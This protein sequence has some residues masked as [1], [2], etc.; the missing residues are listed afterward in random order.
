[1]ESIPIRGQKMTR[2]LPPPYLAGKEFKV[3]NKGPLLRGKQ[4]PNR[5]EAIMLDT[6]QN[7]D[8]IEALR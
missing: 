4:R 1:M 7:L 6:L 8:P 2:S 5:F 3:P